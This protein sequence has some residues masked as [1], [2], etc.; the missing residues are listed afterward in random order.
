M[1]LI[2]IFLALADELGLA[3]GGRGRAGVMLAVILGTVVPAFA[4]LPANLPNMVVLG[5]AETLH[6]DRI[7]YADYLLLH[8]P[9]LGVGYMVLLAE[10]IARTHAEPVR[11]RAAATP[12][13]A[14]P[15][16][17]A[18]RRLLGIVVLALALWAADWLHGISPG[19]VALAAALLCILPGPGVLDAK[20]FERGTGFG[21]FFYVG[22]VLGMVSLIDAS[23][24]AAAL[25]EAALA[26][27]P[28]DPEAPARSFGALVGLASAL[29]LIVTHPG[30]PA[31]LGP[32]APE[33]AEA[34]GL[35]VIAV[36][37][38]QVVGFSSIVLPYQSAPVMVGLQLSGVGL[39]AASRL[40]VPLGLATLALLVPLDYLWW[41]WLGW[42]G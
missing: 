27:L 18:E 33:L 9:L 31:V 5:V 12:A 26:W 35:S 2:P 30:V 19:W 37:M 11:G 1:I 21:V 41:R 32:L 15:W 39:G 7:S 29:G 13:L 3:R 42:I 23:G 8:F 17:P 10:V 24:L 20:A 38:T 28:L 36:L 40:M 6:G 25:G 34:S 4:I 22:G 14:T 16:T